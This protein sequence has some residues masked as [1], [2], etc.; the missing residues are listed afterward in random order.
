MNLKIRE[1]ISSDVVLAEIIKNFDD[2][3]Y[4]VG[5]AVRDFLCGKSTHDRDLIVVNSSARDFS[6]KI[7]QFFDATFIPLDEI[8]KIYRVV[9]K[10]KI[11]YLDI[12]E[13]VGESVEKDL[14]RRDLTINAL[15]VNLKS[16]EILDVTGGISD[17]ENKI[18]RA[19]D[20]KNFED[21]PLRI[22]RVFR[23]QAQTGFRIDDNTL[24]T[25]KKYLELISKP[26]V[27]RINYEIMHLFSGEYSDVALKN[28]DEIGLLEK[29]F[30]IVNELKKVPPNTHHHLRLFEHSLETSRRIGEI[31]KNSSLEV[32]QHMEQ[33]DFGGYSRFAHLKLAGF[34][35][36][37]GK[38][39][40]WTIEQDTGRHRF[41]KHDDVGSK[42]VVQ[43][44]KK[45]AFSNKQIDYISTM[46]K[47]HIYPS[48]LMCLPDVNDKIMMR[49]VRKMEDNS[50]D[51]IIL[52]Q[53]DRLS[54][55]GPAVTEEMVNNNISSLNR[56]LNFYLK[57]KDTLEP[58]P[59]LLDGNDVM[60][61]LNIKPSPELG[62][63]MDALHEAQ[64]NGDVLTREHAVD[65]IKNLK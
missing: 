53:A 3:I 60:K 27:E 48:S 14:L 25:V 26:A 37:I 62:D 13:P 46:I 47:N 2:E 9:L 57:V 52:A 17:L 30:P 42:M 19:I 18:I 24:N 38:F 51:E 43:I 44:L 59:K 32:K 64:I 45:L 11:N 20:E 23:F 55:R 16:L 6:Q 41:L 4:L 28:M 54:A 22:L 12:T 36:D 21:D 34:L 49:Y 65:F 35:H 33:V 58:L 5:G 31:Y 61:I 8:N 1:K 15:A 7:A 56:L 29:I 50:I 10:D 40:T 39:S 63:I